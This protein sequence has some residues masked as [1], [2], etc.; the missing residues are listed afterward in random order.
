MAGHAV[1]PDDRSDVIGEGDRIGKLRGSDDP[2]STAREQ[3]RRCKKE[4]A[5]T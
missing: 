2:G 1:L 5:R 3:H 4:A